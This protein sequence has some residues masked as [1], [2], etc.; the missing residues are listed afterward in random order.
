MEIDDL[1]I[2][3]LKDLQN[4]IG[5]KSQNHMLKNY[6]G[7]YVIVRSR[8]EGVNAG[9]VIDIDETGVVL[10]DARRLYY[11]KPVNKNVSWYEGVAKTGISEDSKVGCAIEKVIV[12]DYSLTI[13]TSD[14]EKSIREAKDNEQS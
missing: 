11:H 13:C 14:A 5:G 7:K 10:G 4:L 2:G 6:I 3:Q 9:K 12:E 1:T 8:N